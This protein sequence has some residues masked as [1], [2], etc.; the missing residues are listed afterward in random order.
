MVKSTGFKRIKTGKFTRKIDVAL[1]LGKVVELY[2]QLNSKEA[3]IL[4]QL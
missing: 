1:H 3:A 2:Q 4:T